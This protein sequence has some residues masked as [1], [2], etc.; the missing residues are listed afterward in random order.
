M[1]QIFLH[2]LQVRLIDLQ[3]H[4]RRQLTIPPLQPIHSLQQQVNA[5]QRR[6]Q[7]SSLINIIKALQIILFA[8]II[9]LINGMD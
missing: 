3:E 7:V 2:Y 6:I 9:Y 1:G 8:Q 5:L 4:G